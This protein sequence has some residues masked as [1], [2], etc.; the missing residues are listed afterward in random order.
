MALHRGQ[1][2]EFAKRLKDK[3]AEDD[4]SGASA[5][6]A[7]RFF[8]ALFPFFIFLAALSSFIASAADVQNPTDEIMSMLGDSLPEDSAAVLRTQLDGVLQQQNAG[9]LSIGIL[10]AIWAASSGVGALMKNMNR[11]YDVEESR[12]MPVRLGIALA[13]TVF[14][15]GTI[16]IAFVILFAGQLYGP[17]IA[18]EV[19]LED[20][21][22][23]VIG[24]ARWP[25]VIA[26]ILAAVAIM[27]WLAPDTE[28]GLKWITPGALFFGV[29]WIVASLGF[30]LYVANFG[31]YNETYG[32]LGAVVVLLI[33]FY[34]TSFVLLLG[35]E[36]NSVLAGMDAQEKA[37]P[38]EEAS[39]ISQPMPR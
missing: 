21:A 18:G 37:P 35:A 6:M 9:L 24:L 7:Y 19:G 5:E 38:T 26:M 11:I 20:T 10:G 16:V 4:V 27:Y 22:A 17:E 12:R 2:I 28:P 31:A 15:A 34:L 29:A 23:S 33:W 30:G 8:L 3:V 14:G 32:A 1:V 39:R 13:I 25:L 36:I